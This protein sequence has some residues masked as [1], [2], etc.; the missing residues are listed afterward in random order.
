MTTVSP[1]AARPASKVADFNC[2]D[3]TGGSNTIGIGIARAGKRQRQT[4]VH[5]GDGAGADA[6]Q[7]IEHAAHRAAAQRGIAVECRRDR[8]AGDRA[9]HQAGTRFPNCRNRALPRAR[10]SRRRR[11]R[12]PAS[13]RSPERSTS[14]PSARKAFAVLRTSSPSSKPLIRVSPTARA[15]RMSARIEIDL[16]PGTRARPAKGPLRRA[17]SGAGS[18]CASR[19]WSMPARRLSR[20]AARTSSCGFSPR[21]PRPCTRDLLLTGAPR[22][23]K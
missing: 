11:R 10:Q 12:G 23:A 14:A 5:R 18:Q 9:E 6:L 8:A 20:G 1:G 17:V 21:K 16:S 15:P 4:A 3:G 22:L 19:G 13:S 2:A 7:R